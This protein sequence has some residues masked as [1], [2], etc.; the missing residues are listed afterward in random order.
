MQRM[1]SGSGSRRIWTLRLATAAILMGMTV[2]VWGAP[3][4]R[5]W[6]K[7]TFAAN[8]VACHMANGKGNKAIG[9]PNFTDPKWQASRTNA[10]LV[11]AI[12]NGVKGTAMPSWKSQFSPAQIHALIKY[13]VRPF[14]EKS[15]QHSS[16]SKK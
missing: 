12:T 4:T 2:P 16:H 6:A 10:Q 15:A 5:A 8:C 9:T 14:G 13:V 7:K 1:A 11:A 3:P